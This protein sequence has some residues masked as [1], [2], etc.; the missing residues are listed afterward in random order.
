M[1]PYSSLQDYPNVPLV[2]SFVAL[3]DALS[4][5]LPELTAV[6]FLHACCRVR[7][8]GMRCTTC[9]SWVSP[10]SE[11]GHLLAFAPDLGC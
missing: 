1:Q 4:I 8:N 2:W 7:R 9:R 5:R 11:P 3:L 6:L 10:E